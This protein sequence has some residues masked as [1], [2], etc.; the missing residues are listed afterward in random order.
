MDERRDAVSPIY[1]EY[2]ISA[3]EMFA[4]KTYPTWRTDREV[5]QYVGQYEM[6][7]GEAF[8]ISYV[9][10]AAK[11]HL[12]DAIGFD[13]KKNYLTTTRIITFH[14]QTCDVH[15]VKDG[16]HRLLQCAFHKRNPRLQVYEVASRDWT[17]CR[18]DMKNFCECISNNALM[19][20][21]L[22]PRS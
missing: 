17:A 1:V 2:S 19:E 15:V 18:V 13:V 21:R 7:P 8:P 10:L 9:E 14:C 3:E 6:P 22:T 5:A 12:F 4:R 16:S 11:S 20:A